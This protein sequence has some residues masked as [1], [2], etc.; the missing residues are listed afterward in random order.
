MAS[1]LKVT[2]PFCSLSQPRARVG[3]ARG[4]KVVQ[5]GSRQAGMEGRGGLSRPVIQD[6]AP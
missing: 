2:V 1:G 5:E 3:V 4:S 6:A